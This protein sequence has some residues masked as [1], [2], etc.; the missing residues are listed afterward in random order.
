MIEHLS[1]VIPA[2]N[3]EHRILPTLKSVEAYCQSR[4]FL[5]DVIVVSDGSTDRT[6]HVVQEHHPAIRVIAFPENRGKFAA[7]RAGIEAAQAPWVLL[8]DADGATPIETIDEFMPFT[9]NHDCIIA[10]RAAEGARVE[11]SQSF[12]RTALGRLGNALIRSFTGLPYID[13]QCGYKLIR[14]DLAKRIASAMT[15][16]RFAGDIELLY[17]ARLYGARITEVG[18]RWHDV[19]VSTVRARDYVFT[20]LDLLKIRARWQRRAHKNE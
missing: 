12:L 2:Y 20:F 19:P 14:T 15:I 16:D 17:L 10:S 11:K 13:T 4:S 18:V 1:I 7:I 8:Y 3:E 9:E 6:V 5:C